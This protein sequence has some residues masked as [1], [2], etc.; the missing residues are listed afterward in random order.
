ME[1]IHVDWRGGAP[2]PGLSVGPEAARRLDLTPK[3]VT[4]L[5][6][7]LRNRRDVFALQRLI[8]EGPGEPLTAVMPGVALDQLWRLVGGGEKMLLAVS[9]LVTITGLMGLVSC[10]L[11]GL[12]ERR[13]ELAIL[14]SVGARPGDV[15]V[16]LALESL[17][18][19]L[20]GVVAGLLALAALVGFLGPVIR[21]L[22]GLAVELSPPTAAEW[23]L[24][25]AVWAAGALSGLIPA[26]RAYRLSLGDGL[27]VRL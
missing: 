22:Y 5:L 8:N 27:T 9:A 14:R 26:W 6:V 11:A 16:L 13:R 21:D 18:L 25:A 23:R 7:G 24:A 4:A 20:A 15:L 12:G 3:S 1:A 19:T 2:I 10:V 17:M